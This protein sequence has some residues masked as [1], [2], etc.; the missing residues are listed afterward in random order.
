ME[1]STDAITTHH[2]ELIKNGLKSAG[3]FGSLG[4]FGHFLLTKNVPRYAKHTMPFKAFIL[5]A[6][7]MAA[8]FTSADMYHAERFKP[9]NTVVE[10]DKAWSQYIVDNQAKIAGYTWLSIMTLALGYNFS[11][12][13]IGFTQKLINSRMVAQSGAL[14][15][16][17]CIA[18]LSSQKP[19]ETP[20]YVDTHFEN[21]I[22]KK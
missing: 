7:P 3:I 2:D 4:L 17:A 9:V 16:I 15:G 11:K 19:K 1:K 12:K 6:I 13:D 5:A 18:F 20:E 22:S 8:F 14:L 21:I 10:S